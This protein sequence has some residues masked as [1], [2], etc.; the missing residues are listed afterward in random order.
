MRTGTS[1]SISLRDAKCPGTRVRYDISIVFRPPDWP[2][3]KAC[4]K[5]CRV[6][7]LHAFTHKSLTSPEPQ[8]GQRRSSSSQGMSNLQGSTGK[9]RPCGLQMS[10]VYHPLLC[11]LFSLP[12]MGVLAAG[13]R[14]PT[15]RWM[16]LF[17]AMF[18]SSSMMTLT[19]CKE[20]RRDLPRLYT[21]F[22]S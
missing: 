10:S 3:T 4:M 19:H 5:Y 14:T 6:N 20:K 9:F 15:L 7:Q 13:W 8:E 17:T 12:K 21:W 1:I 16:T 2:S 11:Q 18:D 22:P